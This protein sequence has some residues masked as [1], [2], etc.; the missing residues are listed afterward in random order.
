[1]LFIP[2]GFSIASCFHELPE[3]A[4]DMA[5]LGLFGCH[6]WHTTEGGWHKVKEGDSEIILRNKVPSECGTN[7][8]SRFAADVT[9]EFD[10]IKVYFEYPGCE[11]INEDVIGK[12]SV[13]VMAPNGIKICRVFKRAEYFEGVLTYED[14]KVEDEK[15]IQQATLYGGLVS[16]DN[17]LAALHEHEGY[18]FADSAIKT[19]VSNL[20][21]RLEKQ[22][23][24]I[25]KEGKGTIVTVEGA[26]NELRQIEE[27]LNGVV[28]KRKAELEK[29]KA[30][31]IARC[32]EIKKHVVKLLDEKSF[33][34]AR[35]VVAEEKASPN[36]DRENSEA[37][38]IALSTL[39]AAKE[40]EEADRK[41]REKAKI[42]EKQNRDKELARIKEKKAQLEK[43]IEEKKY[44]EVVKL[45]DSEYEYSNP[46]FRSEDM[47]TWN[48]IKAKAESA[49]V[50]IKKKAHAE[51]VAK[52]ES[53]DAMAQ[54]ELGK[55]YAYGNEFVQ[56]N[57]ALARKWLRK[58]YD[59]GV[60]KAW[61][62]MERLM[63]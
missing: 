14:V 55:A 2:T 19:S 22:I 25:G 49:L 58:A 42:I 11:N 6:R 60:E 30:N 13:G 44:E 52:A 43:M 29:R 33:E 3:K 21:E 16:V 35:Q 38:M 17:Q 51:L 24:A 40:K 61:Q 47:Q 57:V 50:E 12:G 26:E 62:E 27:S 54:Y 4:E 28:A 18:A 7:K 15:I 63:E 10:G 53:G 48:A 56:K 32:E 5:S 41:A 9:G 59:N 39:I 46:G 37:S 45:C 31:A 8:Q 34:K 36:Y 23:R 20:E 1:M